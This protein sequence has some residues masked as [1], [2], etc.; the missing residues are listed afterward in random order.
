ML[1]NMFEPLKLNFENVGYSCICLHDVTKQELECGAGFV[2]NDACAS[3]LG[4]VG[5]YILYL[6]KHKLKQVALIVPEI[7]KECRAVSMAGILA[8]SLKRAALD[9]SFELIE[10]N[11]AELSSL[12]SSLVSACAGD[13]LSSLASA[14]KGDEL[15]REANGDAREAAPELA[16]KANGDARGFDGNVR[17]GICGNSAIMSSHLFYD[18]I[19]SRV[20]KS[21]CVPVHVPLYKVINEQD[22][23]TP[24]LQYFKNLS[25]DTVIGIV[26]FG[27]LNGHAYARGQMRALLNDYPD[28]QVYILDYD[29]GASD[30]N[31]INRTE[32]VIQS[33]LNA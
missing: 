14:C 2:D 11:N 29:P 24:S 8:T 23:L 28:M 25:I 22:F 26:P 30:V 3:A 33:V 10:I 32:L 31:L 13:E 20:E 17:I 19:T 27:C 5:Q 7:C 16:H 6:Q 15:A 1:S 21:G 18:V 4:L 9:C 12:C